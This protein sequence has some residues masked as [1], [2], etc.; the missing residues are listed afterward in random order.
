MSLVQPSI[1]IDWE[2]ELEIIKKLREVIKYRT[3]YYFGAFV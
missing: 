3:I 1:S 2:K